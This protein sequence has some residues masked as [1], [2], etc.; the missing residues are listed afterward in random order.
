MTRCSILWPVMA[1]ALLLAATAQAA[2]DLLVLVPGSNSCPASGP[3]D[4]L[5]VGAPRLAVP[6]YQRI[7]SA[8]QQHTEQSA[9]ITSRAALHTF[10]RTP[11]PHVDVG[12][13]Q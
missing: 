3:I 4:F 10:M 6:G 5:H 13:L 9:Y 2:V 11:M 8:A 12:M 1:A 7:G